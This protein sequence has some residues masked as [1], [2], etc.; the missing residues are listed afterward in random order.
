MI[1]DSIFIKFDNAFNS[2]FPFPVF[3]VRC[4]FVKIQPLFFDWS[5]RDLPK[6]NPKKTP[7]T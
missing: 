3:L 6:N 1:P 7:E 4:S 2:I 5:I